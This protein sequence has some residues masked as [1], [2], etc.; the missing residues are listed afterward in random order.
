MWRVL[1]KAAVAVV[2]AMLTGGC[3]EASRPVGVQSGG[4]DGEALFLRNC[5]PCHP[6]GSNILF[7]QKNL[8]RMTLAANGITT[9][10]HIIAKMRHP[11]PRMR[12]FDKG[13]LSDAEARKIAEYILAT[14]R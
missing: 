2:A 4:G 6:N 9:P 14:F 5:S 8:Q 7:P 3:K 11:G 12:R 13:D 1:G 10:D